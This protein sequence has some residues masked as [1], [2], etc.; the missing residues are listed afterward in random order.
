MIYSGGEKDLEDDGEPDDGVEDGGYGGD[1]VDVVVKPEPR[2]DQGLHEDQGQE[3][4]KHQ[5]SVSMSMCSNSHIF[6]SQICS[7]QCW[8]CAVGLLCKI[9]VMVFSSYICK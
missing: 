8:N 7:T 1:E 4:N 6:L 9:F 2:P 5:D 3:V